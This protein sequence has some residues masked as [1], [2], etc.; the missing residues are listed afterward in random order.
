MNKTTAWDGRRQ[1]FRPNEVAAMPEIPVSGYLLRQV[2]D[3][4]WKDC[5]VSWG[6]N[7]PDYYHHQLDAEGSANLQAAGLSGPSAEPGRWPDRRLVNSSL[8]DAPQP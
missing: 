2:S 3:V 6:S 8:T 7:R 1:D 5:T 4:I